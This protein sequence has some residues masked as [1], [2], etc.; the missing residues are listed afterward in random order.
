MLY[1]NTIVP[2]S[3]E[4]KKSN[5][6]FLFN[7]NFKKIGWALAVLTLALGSYSIVPPGH[8]GIVINAGKTSETV[9]DEG[10]TL[11]LPFVTTIK[12]VSVRIQ[13][14]KINTQAASRDMQKVH[15]VLSLNWHISPDKVNV[16]FKTIGEIEVIEA[17]IIDKQV[18]EVL[19][20]ATATLSAEEILAKRNELKSRI[21]ADL[22]EKL[23]KFNIT[24]DNVNLADFDF[25]AEFNQ[26]V[27]NKQIAEQRS[28]QAEYE[29]QRATVDARAAVNKAKGQAEASL[30]LAKAE[31]EANALK[32]K[33]LTPELIRYEAISKW[34]GKLPTVQT[35]GGTLISLDLDKK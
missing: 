11:K 7:L 20:A 35:N 6:E 16:V 13:E 28:K 29:A 22:I 30:T 4:K 8:K 5:M 18:S 21:D 27:E 17:N 32:L 34:D 9:L 1:K 10:F 33:T 26:A 25:T 31:A 2:P 12:P 3:T 15:T 19:K 14:T 24:V 23:A